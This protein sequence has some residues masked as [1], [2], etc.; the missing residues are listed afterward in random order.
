MNQFN[1]VLKTINNLKCNSQ[2]LQSDKNQ[3]ESIRSL[4]NKDD[5][6]SSF[7]TGHMSVIRNSSIYRY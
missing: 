7:Y 4:K 6:I 3:K 1:I 5:V 2:T